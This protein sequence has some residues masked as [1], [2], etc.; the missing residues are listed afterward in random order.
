VPG[1]PSPEACDSVDNDCDGLI[2]ESVDALSFGFSDNFSSFDFSRWTLSGSAYHAFYD[3][4]P[5]IVLTNASTWLAGSIFYNQRVWWGFSRSRPPFNYEISFRFWIGG[6]TGADG[7]AFVMARETSTRPLLGGSGGSLGYSGPPAN[8]SGLVVEFDTYNSPGI[9]SSENHVALGW[10]NL[11][12][13]A[14]NDSVFELEDTGWHSARILFMTIDSDTYNVVVYLD[15]GPVIN[16]TFDWLNAP[17]IGSGFYFGFTAA[18][19]GATNWH[20]I[21]DVTMSVTYWCPP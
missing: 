5:K 9:D 20:Q 11:T 3:A 12:T 1:T 8:L 7:L 14:V 6:G 13:L 17:P 16:H 2:D 15:G 18:T 10:T 21:D 4:D 19:G